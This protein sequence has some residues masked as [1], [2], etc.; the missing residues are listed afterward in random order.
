M[1]NVKAI[2]VLKRDLHEPSLEEKRTFTCFSIGI[3]ASYTKNY[4]TVR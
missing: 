4:P 2:I 1:L 3:G